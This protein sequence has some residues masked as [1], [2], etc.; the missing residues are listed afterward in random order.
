[1]PNYPGGRISGAFLIFI[2][3]ILVV[4]GTFILFIKFIILFQTAS[5]SVDLCVHVMLNVCA[6]L[7]SSLL[8]VSGWCP[9]KKNF[10]LSVSPET[11]HAGRPLPRHN[12]VIAA[13]IH[14][15]KIIVYN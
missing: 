14:R 2:P 15:K 10:I 9:A 12:T 3:I 1:M 5:N 4:L 13:P 8:L 11:G 6:L 7:C